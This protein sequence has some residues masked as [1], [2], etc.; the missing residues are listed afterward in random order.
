MSRLDQIKPFIKPILP[1]ITPRNAIIAVVVLIGLKVIH[2]VVTPPTPDY[3]MV[4]YTGGAL[5]STPFYGSWRACQ[6]ASN[7]LQSDWNVHTTG[8]N[9]I[10]FYC[11]PNR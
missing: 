7:Q 5:T 3:S 1:F 6:A 10:I 2:T 8:T 9:G 11:V 4:V